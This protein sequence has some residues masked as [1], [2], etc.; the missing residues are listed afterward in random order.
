[1]RGFG[2]AVQRLRA[3]GGR[4]QKALAP[5]PQA[6]RAASLALVAVWGLW[7]LLFILRPIPRLMPTVLV[8]EAALFAWL[9]LVSLALIAVAWL[10]AALPAGYR[11]ALFLAL[12]PSAMFFLFIWGPV[13]GAIAAVILVVVVSLVAGAAA[14][15]R[16]AER[17]SGRVFATVLLGLGV[18]LAAAAGAALL[19]PPAGENSRPVLAARGPAPALPDPGARGGYPVETFSY[20]SGADRRRPEYAKAVRF[21]T[22]P[23]DGSKLD[24]KWSGL[25]GRLRTLYWGFDAAAMPIQARVWA[26]K[27][28]GPFPLVLVVHGNHAMEAFSEEG[29][30]Y[31]ADHLASHG[32]IVASVDEN[33]INSSIIDAVV[34]PNLRRGEETDARAWL[35][36]QHLAQW[37]AWTG[38][39]RH[40]LHGKAD[41][42]RL[43]LVGHSRGGEAAATAA[44]FNRLAAYPD[45]ATLPFPFGFSLKAIAG[46]APVDGQYKPRDRPTMLEDVSYFVI[47]GSLDGDLQSFMG[48]TQYARTSFSPGFDGFKAALYLK[49]ANHGQFNTSWGRNDL[50][51]PHDFLLD[52]RAI[53]DPQ[54]QRQVMKVYLTAFLQAAVNG[55]E[56]YRALMADPRRGAR[57]LPPVVLVANYQDSRT[58]PVAGY[59]ED[60]DPTTGADRTVRISAHNLSVLRERWAKLKYADLDSHVAFVGW[61]PRAHR[62]GARYAFEFPDL[63]P[64]APIAATGAVVFSASDAG[65]DTLPEGFEPPK[66]GAKPAANKTG[67]DWTVVLVDADGREARV[68]L[69]Y[70]DKLYPQIRSRTRR[71]RWI[72]LEKPSELVLRR[73]RLPLSAFVAAN[74]ELDLGRIRAIRFDFDRS[75]RGLIAL[76]DV[77][78]SPGV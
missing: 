43:A 5:S 2:A 54:A 60:L 15:A 51:Y 78:L 47:H 21:R 23:V 63:L 39:P 74:P 25:Q 20:G 6:W 11:A 7:L 35:L 31:L 45:D 53:L 30:A 55:Q 24:R 22:R 27:G 71:A 77:G 1:M 68:P 76:E 73:F 50:G 18:V 29:Y 69:S 52:E 59:D 13:G 70:D 41:L 19:A 62:A 65:D 72:D 8:G 42:E 3:L 4:L 16:Q 44:A 61:D 33:F 49:D 66:G 75:P 26:P 9:A 14:A 37:R 34:L 10:L 17:R 32:F 46:I 48:Q 28:A 36:L 56:G 57:W 64:L 40:P 58:A 12:A 38:D 67:L